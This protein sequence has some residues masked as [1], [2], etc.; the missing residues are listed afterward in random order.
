MWNFSQCV[1]GWS[2]RKDKDGYPI[3]RLGNKYRLVARVFYELF[4]GPVP[5]GHEIRHACDNRACV[6]PA[7]L[8]TGTHAENMADARRRGRHRRGM[9]SPQARYADNIIAEVRAGKHSARE[10][11]ALWGMS[12][13]QFYRIRNCESRV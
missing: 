4:V 10:A 6:N 8:T 2:G 3:S 12:K 5:P 1:T 11:F 13:S 9:E 7:H